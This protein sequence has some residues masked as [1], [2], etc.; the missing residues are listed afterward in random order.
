VE[1]AA[2][3]KREYDTVIA[4]EPSQVFKAVSDA[5]HELVRA[6]GDPDRQY[7]ALRTSV[8]NLTE[9]AQALAAVLRESA[10]PAG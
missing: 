10:T 1:T 6:L 9:K 8:A 5:H 2:L 7:E 4:V 3:R